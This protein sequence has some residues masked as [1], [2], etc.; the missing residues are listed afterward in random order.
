[1][2]LNITSHYL[3]PSIYYIRNILARQETNDCYSCCW[4]NKNE[5]CWNVEVQVFK[6][7]K[8]KIYF[9]R[10]FNKIKGETKNIELPLNLNKQKNCM[11]YWNLFICTC[12]CSPITKNSSAFHWFYKMSINVMKYS[13]IP[14]IQF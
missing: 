3:S 5:E 8:N 10:A 6:C 12:V 13:F 9:P 2:S 11:A 14:H 7:I 1:M 4:G